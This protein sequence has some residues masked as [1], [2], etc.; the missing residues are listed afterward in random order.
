MRRAFFATILLLPAFIYSSA[1]FIYLWDGISVNASFPIP[2][3]LRIGE[4]ASQSAYRAAASSLLG[5]NQGNGDAQIARAEAEFRATGNSRAARSLVA[6]GLTKSPAS[7]EGWI[8]YAELWAPVDPEKAAQALHISYAISPQDFFTMPRRCE[9]AA[10][11]WPYLAK[12]D[13]AAALQ[14]T[15]QL[16]NI[17]SLRPAMEILTGTAAGRQ[18]VIY[19]WVDNPE[20]IRSINRWISSENRQKFRSLR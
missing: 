17:P 4:A 16:W 2:L 8:L 6:Q 13:Q 11:I 3:H 14:E 9:L 20:Q 15:R 19:A 12:D 7:V 5:A 18:L 10:V 1:G